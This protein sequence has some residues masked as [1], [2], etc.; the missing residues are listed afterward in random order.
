M[1]TI[2]RPFRAAGPGYPA[3]V[4]LKRHWFSST[5]LAGG[6]R[7]ILCQIAGVIALSVVPNA[8]ASPQ[9]GTVVAGAAS[10]TGAAAAVTINQSSQNVVINWQSFSIAPNE[11]VTFQQP[12]GNSVALNRVTGADP[13]AILGSLSAN[14]KVF[15]VNPNGVLFA[16]GAQVNVGGLVASTL[17]IANGDFM[18]G[19][20]AFTGSG[21]GDVLN[22]GSITADGGYVALLGAQVV[23]EGV[24]TARLGSVVLAAGRAMTL[25]IAGDGLLNVAVDAGA[26]DALARNSGLIQADGG[27]VVMTAKS[28]GD[29]IKTA[30]N[31]TGIIEAHTIET[32][33]G[34]IRLLGDSRNGT[35][36]VAGTLDASA[37]DGGDGGVIETSAAN[38]MIAE[39]A[40]VTTAAV[41]GS[42]G[43]WSINTIGFTIAPRRWQCFRRDAVRLA[44]GEQRRHLHHSA[45]Y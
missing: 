3:C 45:R 29:L 44:G 31:N 17:D 41:Q 43:T 4:D 9:N 20:Y 22:Q 35:V 19:S 10:I 16:P 18:E 25:D 40:R 30:V 27:Q 11:A 12:N 13:S 5:A 6:S 39:E 1:T 36:E 15:L 37:P 34:T 24:I 21:T 26:V 7:V 23:N 14:G 28:A 2:S 38:V 32:R 8:V 33:E 42:T